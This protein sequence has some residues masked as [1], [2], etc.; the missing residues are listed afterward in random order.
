MPVKL[1]KDKDRPRINLDIDWSCRSPRVEYAEGGRLLRVKFKRSVYREARD[2]IWGR[3]AGARSKCKGFSFGSRR[4][5]LDRLNTV[6]KGAEL[7]V[8][9][10]LTVPDE[11]FCLDRVEFAARA[12]VW[13]DVFLKRLKRAA[14]YASAFWRIEW[15][16]RKSGV[17]EGGYAPHFHLLIWGL[18]E[19]ESGRFNGLEPLMEPCVMVE[20]RQL[21]LD[22]LQ[23]LSTD[24]APEKGEAVDTRDL[25]GRQFR[26]VGK[27]RYLYRCARL[28]AEA[29]NSTVEGAR[30]TER[31]MMS[32]QDWA[33]LAW[34]HVVESRNTDHLKAGA[35]AETIRTWG[36]VMCYATKYMSKVEADAMAPVEYGR[37]WGIHNRAMLPWAKIVTLELPEDVGVTLRRVARRY[38]EHCTGRKRNY[39]Y[40]ITLYCNTENFIRLCA[41]PPD[42]PF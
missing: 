33:S 24:K 37:N 29:Y 16:D 28:Y 19:R 17:Y 3:K 20:D 22:L 21:K 32:L 9:L 27:A 34:Y 1:L 14:P 8:F 41:R 35:R 26:F 39:A 10:T 4:R 23:E 40:G 15:Q 36:G 42:E 5:L 2:E 31:R 7:P 30:V 11:V 12:K 25:D 38:M 6:S 13:L 18:P